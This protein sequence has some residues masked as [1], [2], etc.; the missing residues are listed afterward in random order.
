MTEEPECVEAEWIGNEKKEKPKE[1]K[2]KVDI[3]KGSMLIGQGILSY[4]EEMQ[5]KK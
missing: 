4:L 2:W 5:K 3:M 1:P